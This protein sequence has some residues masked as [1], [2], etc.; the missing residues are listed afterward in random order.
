MMEDHFDRM[1]ATDGLV[2]RGSKGSD[3]GGPV[4]STSEGASQQYIRAEK[5][6]GKKDGYVFQMGPHG[7][8]Y[9]YDQYQRQASPQAIATGE[10]SLVDKFLFF[11]SPLTVLGAKE[12][13]IN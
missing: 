1:L 2:G 13:K 10:T 7:L 4:T 12:K 6:K 8:G 9:Y 11:C 5:F 3:G